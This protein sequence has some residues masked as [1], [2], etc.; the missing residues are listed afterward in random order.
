MALGEM[1]SNWSFDADAQR[2]K[3]VSPNPSIERTSLNKL[4]CFRPPIMSNVWRD[5]AA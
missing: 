3:S 1:T 4:R 5:S 2:L